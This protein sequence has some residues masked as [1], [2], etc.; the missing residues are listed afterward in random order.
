VSPATKPPASATGGGSDKQK[1]A[2]KPKIPTMVPK[3]NPEGETFGLPS[4]L[5]KNRIINNKE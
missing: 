4:G 2:A 1:K 3:K 5:R